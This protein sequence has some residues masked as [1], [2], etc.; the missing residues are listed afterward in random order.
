[1]IKGGPLLLFELFVMTLLLLLLL[2]CFHIY[3]SSCCLCC[4]NHLHRSRAKP[5]ACCIEANGMGQ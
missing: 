2:P 5:P 4:C 3:D 1:M